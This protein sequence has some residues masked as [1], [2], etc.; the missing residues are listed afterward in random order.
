MPDER[1]PPDDPQE[2]LRRAHS[3]L[4]RARQ[5]VPGVYLEDLCFDAHPKSTSSLRSGRSRRQR[6]PVKPG[7]I[8]SEYA[9]AT[10]YPGLDEPVTEEEHEEAVAIA[11][12]VVR[13][14][15]SIVE[16]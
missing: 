14:V 12:R 6:K 16:T 2:W 10:R 9:T 1:L 8:L 15:E 5:R 7:T 3:N 13:W 4:I 11:E